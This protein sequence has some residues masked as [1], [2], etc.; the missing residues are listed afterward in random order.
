[1]LRD[2]LK[3]SASQAQKM[4]EEVR[5]L[6]GRWE[7][8][9][10][11]EGLSDDDYSK[12]GMAI[13]LNNQAKQLVQ[14]ANRTGTAAN[15]E[16]WSGVALPLIRRIMS[17]I[18]AQEFLSFQPMNLPTG[19]VFYIDFK[20]GSAQTGFSSSNGLGSAVH[21]QNSIFGVTDVKDQTPV[22]GLYGTGRFGYTIN[23]S[24]SAALFAGESATV[25]STTAS[26]ATLT[27]G[28]VNYDTEF[29]GSNVYGFT[30]GDVCKVQVSTASL[31]NFDPL[32]V[33]A[34]SITGSAV[35][36][37]Y[38]KYTKLVANDTAV[39]FVIKLAATGSDLADLVVGYHKQPTDITR[40][41]FEDTN[42]DAYSHEDSALDIPTLDIK[43][44]SETIVAKTRKLKTQWTPEFSQDLDAYH[45]IDAEAELTGMMSE[46]ISA[47]IDLELI[48]M[49]SKGATTTD[50][51]SATPGRRWNSAT[52][53]FGQFSANVEFNQQ[54]WF[55]TLGTKI[56]KVSNEIHRKTLRGG[57]NFL[58][59]SPQ[60]ATIIE[61]MGKYAAAT[62]GTA[63]KFSFGVERVGVLQNRITVYK[64]PY[65]TSNEVL[66]G[67]RGT[68]FL[69]TGAIYAPYVP[70]IST[71]T[72][73]DPD[74][75][76]PRRGLMTRYAKK[77]VRGSFYGKI[78]V[79]GLET[80]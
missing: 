67:Y 68:S 63:E 13:L 5:G 48:D 47:E 24:N 55:N 39:Q 21:Q 52:N 70:L 65:I 46:Y 33:S 42:P 49:L 45:S 62:D 72:V 10:L 76:T 15:S 37:H 14:E 58:V 6:V 44:E 77:L 31:S 74:N 19:L 8:F 27:D 71:P 16:E 17:S 26:F 75:M 51:W 64:N 29:S 59:C 11:L 53:T 20:Y 28:D 9:G 73:Y 32:G 12:S 2:I 30:T 3:E 7:K 23:D 78:Y 80:L 1:M 43:M 79:E 69:E 18:S 61:S 25:T 34:F 54:T 40:G 66:M 4:K 60:V 57:A 41:D 36:T 22:G 50:F 56:Q 38:S 35:D